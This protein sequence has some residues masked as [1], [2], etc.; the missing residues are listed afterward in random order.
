MDTLSS[1]A[2]PTK[3]ELERKISQQIHKLH[4][5]Q[6]GHS[7]GKITCQLVDE[8]LFLVVEDSVTKPEQ[9]LVERGETDLAATVRGDLANALQSEITH[10]I[11]TLLSSKV[12]DVL[13]DATLETGRTGIV[14]VLSEP[15]MVRLNGKASA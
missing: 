10:L 13:S 3:G 14:I 2:I 11:E 7:P 5:E 15:P 8:K 12:V 6:L 9:L 1:S 4:R